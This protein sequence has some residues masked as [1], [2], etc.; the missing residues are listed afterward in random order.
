MAQSVLSGNYYS[1]TN[2]LLKASCPIASELEERLSLS[3]WKKSFV[4]YRLDDG[5]LFLC[6]TSHEF[7]LSLQLN[8]K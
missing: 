1:L 8:K 5:R 4:K 7:S 3:L 6:K 2:Q